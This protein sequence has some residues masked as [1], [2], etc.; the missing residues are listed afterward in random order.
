M[1]K[2]ILLFTLFLSFKSISQ[3]KQL[4]YNFTSVPQSLMT[5]PGADFKYKFYF[6]IPLISGVS[7]NIGSTGFS[8]SDLFANDGVDFN[9]K[10]RNVLFS[11]TSKDHLAMNQQIEVFNAGFKLGNFSEESHSYLSFGM[12]EEF[13]MLSYMP[14]DIAILALDGN[15]NYL[16]K[17][18]NL[19]DLNAKAEMLSVFHLGYNT[20]ISDKL[21]VGVRGKI[22]SSI[23]NMSSTNNSG[24]I[25]TTTSNVGIYDQVIAPNIV[26]NTSGISK[27]RFIGNGIDVVGDLKSKALLGGNLGLGFDAGLT[28]YPQKNI[29]FTASIIDIGYVKHSKEVESFTYKGYYKYDGIN[30]KFIS[31]GTISNPLK[32][33]NNA[34]PLDTLYSKYTSWRPMKFNSSIQYS[35]EEE[36]AT[37]CDCE[38]SNS[39]TNY[40]SAIGAQLFMMSTPVN[41]LLAF[42]TYYRR[43]FGSGL[44]IK[45]TYTLDSYSS[46]NLGFGLSTNIGP[47]NLY[48]LADNLLEYKDVSKANSLSFQFGINV[49]FKDVASK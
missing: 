35:F 14:K 28:Y 42:T 1:R 8:A 29:Q 23:F 41:P 32:D 21:I 40:K 16:G 31:G 3:N 37:D 27:Y 7:A 2:I 12:Y 17:V 18:F 6:G 39:E 15:K 13:D 34:I 48:V 33:F 30:P 19:G 26:I 24:Y 49:V 10:L 11:T 25:Y 43:R 44:Q 46:K 20:H 38:N 5:N 47:V 36:R 45:A 9:T 4:L 22:Y